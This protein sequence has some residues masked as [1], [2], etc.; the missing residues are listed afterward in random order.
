M[1]VTLQGKSLRAA[2]LLLILLRL[3]GSSS[4]WCTLS[5]RG[6]GGQRARGSVRRRGKWL[7]WRVPPEWKKGGETRRGRA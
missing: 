1:P 7:R 5:R 4:W 3:S 6:S 2:G